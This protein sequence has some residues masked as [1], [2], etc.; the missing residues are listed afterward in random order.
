MIKLGL[1]HKFFLICE[2]IAVTSD[3]L[4][5]MA[6]L[7][8]E[9]GAEDSTDHSFAQVGYSMDQPS[10]RCYSFEQEFISSAEVPR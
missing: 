5:L 1:A 6:Y 9:I 8:R 4:L 3:M 2:L 10:K 7:L